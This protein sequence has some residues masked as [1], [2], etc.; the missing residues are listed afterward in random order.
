ME[1][2]Q[3]GYERNWKQQEGHT[4]E[5]GDGVSEGGNVHDGVRDGRNLSVPAGRQV[6][7]STLVTEG[8]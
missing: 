7:E 3:A 2:I 8:L 1:L 4:A 6:T 5:E